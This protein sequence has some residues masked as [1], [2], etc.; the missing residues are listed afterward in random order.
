MEV[1]PI[2]ALAFMEKFCPKLKEKSLPILSVAVLTINK[3]IK[4]TSGLYRKNIIKIV[5]I[6][7]PIK[8]KKS[9]EKIILVIKANI[10]LVIKISPATFLDKKPLFILNNIL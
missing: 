9:A 8:I 10:K 7:K 2:K 5:K 1:I 3:I 4:P 6:K